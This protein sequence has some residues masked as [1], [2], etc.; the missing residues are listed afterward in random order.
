MHHTKGFILRSRKRQPKQDQRGVALITTLLLLM[1]LTGLTLSMAWSARSDMLING[2]Y[3]NFRGSF[4]AADSGLNIVRQAALNQFVGGVGIPAT[5]PA[6]SQPIPTGTE[7]TI[8]ANI[9]T[10]FSGYQKIN[11]GTVAANSWPEQFR[12]PTTTSFTLALDPFNG[13]TVLPAGGTC[14]A[15]PAA[16]TSYKYIYDYTIT[17][18]GQSKGGENATL[19][20]RGQLTLV[21]TLTNATAKTNFAAWGMFIDKQTECG[22]GTLVGGTIT[23]PVFTNGGWTFGNTT[24][25]FT[26]TVGQADANA[27]YSSGG[28]VKVPG[29]SGN[30]ITPTFQQ[31][32]NLS[33]AAIPL[34]TDSFNQERAVLDGQGTNNTKPTAAELN[35]GM[36]DAKAGAKYPSGGASS[37]VFLPYSVDSSGN[38]TLTGG[39]ILVEGNADSVVLT[40]SGAA[41]Q[42]YQIK[43][44]SDTTVITIDATPILS[45]T[46]PYPNGKT[47]VSVNGAAATTISGVPQQINS[48]T[49]LSDGPGTMLYVNGSITSL[50]G[51]GQGMAGINDYTALTITSAGNVTV[52]GDLLYKSPPV[53]LAASGSTPI[54]SLIAGNDHKQ[55]LGIFTASGDIQMN[56]KQPVATLEIDASLAAISAGGTGGLINTGSALSKLVIVGGRI[57][58]QI[59]NINATTRNV[60]F[61]VRYSGGTFAPPWFPSTTVSVTGQKSATWGTAS[62]QRLSWQNLTATY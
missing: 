21:A 3:R 37:G 43:Q 46:P 8:A 38:R 26:G 47:M 19:F 41:G 18:Q 59:D 17:V 36:R 27:G 48:A 53:T 35:A 54:D 15:P 25:T 4:Y 13:C 57:Q 32:F 42:I 2:Y 22:G 12:L 28:C 40:P 61:D 49:G 23:G 50:S 44:G 34:P 20:D 55:T 9:N 5:F 31:G 45:G 1:L 56:N 33:Q 14:A 52:T 60:M 10:A 11:T 7:A 29:P 62:A 30:G 58:S 16:P 51:P 6:T 24:Y 39:G